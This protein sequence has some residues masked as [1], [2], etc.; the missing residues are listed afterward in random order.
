MAELVHLFTTG[1]LRLSAEYH[2]AANGTR[3]S[4]GRSTGVV[5][6]LGFGSVKAQVSAWGE[7]LSAAGFAVLVPDY[8]GFGGS[9]GTR[10]RIVPE[11]QVEDLRAP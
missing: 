5:V 1:G 11:E 8:R 10:G 9:E 6:C 3:P 2:P 7:R 4:P